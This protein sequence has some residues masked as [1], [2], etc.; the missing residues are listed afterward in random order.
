MTVSGTFIRQ[1]PPPEDSIEDPLPEVDGPGT[2]RP[3]TGSTGI[4]GATRRSWLLALP[5]VALL[6]AWMYTLTVHANS[7]A[8]NSDGATVILQGQA[9]ASGNVLL[10]GWIL[11]LDSWWTLDV[12]FYGV[13]TAVTGV[14]GELLLVGPALIAGSVVVVGAVLAR[15]G[16]RGAAATAGMVAV[17]AVLALPTHTLATYL[18]CGPIHVSTALYALVAFVGLRQNRFGWGWVMAVLLLTAGMLG[19]L[20]MVSYGVLPAL[21]GGAAASARRRS[22]RAGLATISAGVG[23][24]ALTLAVR[25]LVVALGGFALGPTNDPA[26]AHQMLSNVAR[27]AP[28]W[29]QL[30]GLGDSLGGSGG[31]PFALQSVH[32]VLAVLLGVALA[33]G[34]VR[35]VGGVCRGR[36]PTDPPGPTTGAD[37]EP[38][39]VDDL[40]VIALVGSTL[41]FVALAATSSG[42]VRYLTASVIFGAVLA[43]RYVTLWW[44]TDHPTVLRRTVLAIGVLATTAFLA[45][46]AVQLSRPAPS[47]PTVRLAAFLESHGLTSGVGDF[48]AASLTTVE[49]NGVVSVRPV[50]PDSSTTLEAYNKGDDPGWFAGH[51][52]QFVVYPNSTAP[53]SPTQ[54]SWLTADATWGR[55]SRTYDVAGYV[56]L[57]W[58][59]PIT[60]T[61]FQPRL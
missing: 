53:S 27:L 18:M 28:V 5:G 32:I 39:R 16:R 23:A 54:V 44:A 45:A 33:V 36:T 2:D 3:P 15:R 47:H 30:L 19:D 8:V 58:P 6:M 50:V 13:L 51:S 4:R 22:L 21:L 49:S 31:V 24:V 52:F 59:H 20:Q 56:V 25:A 42:Y 11:S 43:G 34:A 7:T 17:A 29:G 12:A 10:H 57:V 14:R 1:G 60:V 46:S 40:L 35:L 38:W 26:S 61:R 9:A 55:P 41:N 37:P 48:W